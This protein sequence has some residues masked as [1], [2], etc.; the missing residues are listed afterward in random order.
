ML[1]GVLT[2]CGTSKKE[3]T[4]EPQATMVEEKEQHPFFADLEKDDRVILFTT[5]VHHKLTDYM[6]YDG[7]MSV[8]NKVQDIVTSDH[9]IL[10]DCGDCLDCGD[11]GEQTKG[12]GIAQIMDYVGVDVA[13]PGNHD[14][15]YGVANVKEIAQSANFQY[16]SCNLREISSGNQVLQPYTIIEK[17]GVK[18]GIIGVTTPS[19][20]F[21]YEGSN[22][23]AKETE[24]VTI[25]SSA[26]YDF[27]EDCLF[28]QVQNSVD[29]VKAE[30]AEYVVVVA[31][32]GRDSENYSSLEMIKH[33]TG[34]NAVIDGHEH[35]EIEMETCQNADGEDVVLT[36]SGEYMIAV[37][38]LVIKSDGTI[39]SSLLHVAD[40]LEK[41]KETTEFIEELKNK[42]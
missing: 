1:T 9:A 40:Y 26:V 17:D 22:D 5:D 3:N 12:K 27:S 34:I 32:L 41:D 29:Q 30:G 33:T 14:F 28:E 6:G 25:D 10:V 2:A 7:L 19:S 31:H 42:N 39:S 21:T 24:E 35:I 15:K 18:I 38:K 20:T 16:L 11:L 13:V 23:F 37:G 8:K 36:S 4:K